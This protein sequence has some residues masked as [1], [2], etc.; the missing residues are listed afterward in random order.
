[1]SALLAG[2]SLLALGRVRADF[3][4]LHLQSEETESVIWVQKIF[5]S[6]KRSVLY[7]ELVAESPGGGQAQDRRLAGAALRGAG[8]EHR[9]RDP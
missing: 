1:M 3:N 2:L 5:A 7:G 8:R 4:L 9:L 6:T